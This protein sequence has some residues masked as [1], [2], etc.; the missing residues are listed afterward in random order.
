M[1][2]VEMTV[3]QW[4]AL[5]TYMVYADV[6]EGDRIRISSHAGGHVLIGIVDEEGCTIDEAEFNVKGE[7]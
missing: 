7:S 3:E 4:S 1:S 6:H 5:S 2:V